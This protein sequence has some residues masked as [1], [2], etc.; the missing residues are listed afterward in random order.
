MTVVISNA[1]VLSRSETRPFTPPSLVPRPA[2]SDQLGT[3]KHPVLVQYQSIELS[4]HVKTLFAT[5]SVCIDVSRIPSH[6]YLFDPSA[7]MTFSNS[8]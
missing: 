8:I 5:A 7:Q 1:S 6:R 2:L 3:W 4:S